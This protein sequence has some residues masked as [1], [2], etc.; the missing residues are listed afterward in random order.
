MN[1]VVLPKRFGGYKRFFFSFLSIVLFL[2][3]PLVAQAAF[4]VSPAEQH[5]EN[6]LAG[7]IVPRQVMLT[8][9]NPEHDDTVRVLIEGTNKGAIIGADQLVLPAGMDQVPYYFNIATAGLPKDQDL[10][11][12][13]TF[14]L[15]PRDVPVGVAGFALKLTSVIKFRVTDER[16]DRFVVRQMSFDAKQDGQVEVSYF[17]KNEGNVQARPDTIRITFTDQKTLQE[18][19]V[20]TIQGNEIPSLA[21]FEQDNVFI[22]VKHN[23]PS[24][25]YFI[26]ADMLKNTQV[27]FSS[28]KSAL[29]VIGSASMVTKLIREPSFQY[30]FTVIVMGVGGLVWLRRDYRTLR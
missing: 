9:A 25:N 17:V 16:V 5:I 19:G 30:S 14:L 12:N 15:V 6:I 11:A 29:Q 27:I 22:D 4:G 21:A 23:L 28:G 2:G 10:S 18:A 13:I 20:M 3:S 7:T 26:Q 8:R 24:G 1:A